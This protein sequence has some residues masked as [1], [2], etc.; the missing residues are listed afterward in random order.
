VVI[1]ETLKELHTT[2]KGDATLSSL[3]GYLDLRLTSDG[4]T[5]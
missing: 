2:L 5:S 4:L 1:A 3:G